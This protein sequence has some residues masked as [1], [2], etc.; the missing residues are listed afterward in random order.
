MISLVTGLKDGSYGNTLKN[1]C[2]NY[3]YDKKISFD[4]NFDLTKFRLEP[5]LNDMS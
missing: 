2:K 5:W 4:K 1:C 3:L